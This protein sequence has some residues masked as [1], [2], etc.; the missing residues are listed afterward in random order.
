MNVCAGLCGSASPN[1]AEKLAIIDKLMLEAFGLSDPG[2]VRKN[3]EDYFLLAP[4]MG[5]Y[6]VADGMGG[7]QAGERASK[8]AVETVAKFMRA[9]QARNAET[10]G[11]AFQ[12]ANRRVMD[13]AAVDIELEGMGTTLVALLECADE[14]AIASVGDSRGYVFQEGV[15]S[16]VT[17]DQTWVQ[18][19][20]RRLGLDETKLRNHPMRHVL[21]MAI[22]ASAG[23]KIHT[24]SIPR[25]PGAQFLLSSDGLHGVVSPEIIAETLRSERT[26]EA[27]CHYLIEAARQ[28]GG[29]DN[30]TCVLLRAAEE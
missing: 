16:P 14:V 26:L 22:G 25:K 3:N 13:A 6:I 19:V 17:V 9:Q 10:L 23:L 30:I 12:E 24:Y 28:A 4:E 8:L 15:L 20:G 18:E 1:N 11:M 27:K 29:P 21:T 7:A 2:C 5:L